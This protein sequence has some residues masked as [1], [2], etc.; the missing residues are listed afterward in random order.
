MTRYK[1]DKYYRF[2]KD[3]LVKINTEF[4]LQEFIMVLKSF[5]SDSESGL[6]L[7]KSGLIDNLVVEFNKIQEENYSFDN[8]IKLLEN[9]NVTAVDEITGLL[10]NICL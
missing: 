8:I 6:E 1:S 7:E 3:K 5:K 2:T 10:S 9:T 4:V